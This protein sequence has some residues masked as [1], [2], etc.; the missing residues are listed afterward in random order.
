MC[1]FEGNTRDMDLVFVRKVHTGL[2]IMDLKVVSTEML[3]EAIVESETTRQEGI[4]LKENRRKNMK[5]LGWL[6]GRQRKT[7]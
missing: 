3:L 2:E 7:S 4:N 6:R 5:L 1:T